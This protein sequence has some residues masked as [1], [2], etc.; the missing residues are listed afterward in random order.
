MCSRIR[1]EVGNHCSAN[2]LFADDQIVIVS[3]E[4]DVDYMFRKL[5]DE[6]E[7]W[8][9]AIIMDKI[10]YIRLGDEK[11]DPQLQLRE[12]KNCSKHKYLGCITSGTGTSRRELCNWIQ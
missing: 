7:K 11:E 8:G 5:R 3:D 4:E 2:L 10:K 6:Y 1:I 12:I 9:L